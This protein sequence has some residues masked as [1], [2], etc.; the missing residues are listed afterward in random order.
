MWRRPGVCTIAAPLFEAPRKE[1]MRSLAER[2]GHFVTLQQ[3]SGVLARAASPV[4][5]C[6]GV[7]RRQ[8][9]GGQRH[10]RGQFFFPPGQRPA[11]TESLLP[12]SIHWFKVPQR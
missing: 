3:R 2:L 5:K 8:Q 7:V 4:R 9:W 10:D 12:G 1:E 6:R 11:L